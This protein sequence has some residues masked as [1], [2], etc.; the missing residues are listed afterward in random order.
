LNPGQNFR[1]MKERFSVEQ[2]GLAGVFDAE[3]EEVRKV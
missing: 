3:V 2:G 1:E